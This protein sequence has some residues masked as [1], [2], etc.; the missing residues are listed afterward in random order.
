M[1]ELLFTA[2]LLLAIAL[3]P[4]W[5]LAGWRAG[6]TTTVRSRSSSPEGILA[7]ELQGIDKMV[8]SL[9]ESVRSLEF[10]IKQHH[11]CRNS[12]LPLFSLPPEILEYI[13]L[14]VVP[15]PG[16]RQDLSCLGLVCSWWQDIIFCSGK[17]WSNVLDVNDDQF[18]V[19]KVLER[20]AQVPFGVHAR[21]MA[22][23]DEDTTRNLIAVLQELPHIHTLN[24][25]AHCHFILPLL[26]HLNLHLPF[27]TPSL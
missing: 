18:W 26:P 7:D 8:E 4:D 13:F 1:I 5:W 11:L 24:I 10:R 22:P 20:S 21:I 15:F 12:L 9:H 19:R 27:S 14:L 2:I 16:Q 17:L 25:R 3:G 6:G 23:Y